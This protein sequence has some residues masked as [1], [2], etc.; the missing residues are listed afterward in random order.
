MKNFFTIYFFSISLFSAAQQWDW[1]KA[2]ATNLPVSTDVSPLQLVS[3]KYGNFYLGY[4]Y[5]DSNYGCPDGSM[6][7]K[8][9]SNGNQLWQKNF[10]S[11]IRVRGIAC[12]SD[13]VLYM[14]GDFRDTAYFDNAALVS[15]GNNDAF[16]V[17]YDA[18]G[19]VQWIKRSG[20]TYNDCGGGLCLDKEGNIYMTGEYSDSALFYGNWISDNISNLTISKFD[21][22][23][24]LLLYKTSDTPDSLQGYASGESI[25]LDRS[26]NMVVLGS[27]SHVKIDT[28]RL[29]NGGPYGAQFLC[30]LDTAGDLKW[31][32]GA[33]SFTDKYHDFFIADDDAF[34]AAG[35]G[36]WTNGTW[37]ITNK[38]DPTG[39]I[40]WHQACGLHCGY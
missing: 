13:G 30:K 3:D 22:S 10:T 7:A 29:D 18:G 34:Y 33:T 35:G 40:L 20:G 21:P 2:V 16:I 36:S 25:K 1:A 17:K 11:K 37:T 12:D 6:V 9:D 32:K 39:N 28:A 38:L 5:W 26:G 8:F 15:A 23:G 24:N 4:F 27:Y 19:Q 31:L 14:T